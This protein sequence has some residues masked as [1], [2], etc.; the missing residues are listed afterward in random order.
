MRK[1][2]KWLGIIV[3]VLLVVIILAAVV[4]YFVGKNN[5]NK[6]YDDIQVEAVAIPTGDEAIARGQHIAEAISLCSDCHGMDL[7]GKEFFT[8][9]DSMFGSGDAPNLTSGAG[10]VGAT[11]TDED[12]VRAIRHGVKANGDAIKLMPSDKY[13][14]MSDEDLGAVIAYVK[15]VPPV[16]HDTK[17]VK[18]AI[19][20]TIILGNMTDLPAEK[21]DHE[22]ERPVAPETG[23]TAEYGQ[24]LVTIGG[25]QDC[26]GDKL[27]G[28]VPMGAP[29]GPNLV[30]VGN[31]WTEEQFVS[32][33][34]QGVTPDGDTLD[35]NDM[36]WDYY[37]R[38]TDDE[39]SAIWAYISSLE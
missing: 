13:Y 39:L 32:A 36:P 5:L 1:V 24:Y 3:G 15:S 17:P 19:L 4:L 11:Y 2:L 22:A 26:H 27:K 28:N 38:M 14:T 35:P 33:I 9:D 31:E 29:S 18:M 30:K 25:C 6:S 34:R 23:I 12:W 7:S 37:T 16:D 8:D 21:I 10:G 20:G